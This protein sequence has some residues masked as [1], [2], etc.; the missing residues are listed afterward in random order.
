MIHT[1]SGDTVCD[2]TEVAET[3]AF[4]STTV[5]ADDLAWSSASADETD[6]RRTARRLAVMPPR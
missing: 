6:A 5:P 4:E 1:A 2:E 3:I